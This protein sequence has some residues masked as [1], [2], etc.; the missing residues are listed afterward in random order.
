MLYFKETIKFKTWF[1]FTYLLEINVKLIEKQLV[2]Y[3]ESTHLLLHRNHLFAN[4]IFMWHKD[5][6]DKVK[7]LHW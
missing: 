2:M 7:I 1:S 4:K 3:S 6:I 5:F